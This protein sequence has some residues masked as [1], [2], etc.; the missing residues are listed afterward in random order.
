ME[1]VNAWDYAG[2]DKNQDFFMDGGKH[3][4]SSSKEQTRANLDSISSFLKTA[5]SSFY[6]LQDHNPVTAAFV[7][8]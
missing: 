7:L 4:R 6:L 8:K 3:S 1:G 2:L 5:H